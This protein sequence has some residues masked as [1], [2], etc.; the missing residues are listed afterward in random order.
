MTEWVQAFLRHLKVKNFSVHTLQSY[1]E[2]LQQFTDFCATRNFTRVQDFT[3]NTVRLFL[4]S[5][6]AHQYERN[7]TLRKISALRS[8]AGYLVEQGQIQ[9]NPFKLLPAPKRQR[10]LPKFLTLQEVNRL[11]D[12]SAHKGRFA[13]RNQALVELMYSSGLRRSEI[14]GLTIADVDFFNGVVKVLGKGNKERFVPVTQEALQA[15]RQYLATRPAYKPSD[16]L[17]LG[18][19]G[20]P[21]TGDGLAY[22]FKNL[23]IQS[24]I[25]RRMSPHSM[26]H[27]F[28]TH[29]LN[30]GCDL[31]SLQEMLGHSSLQSTQVY[32]HVSLDKLKNVYQHAHPKSKENQL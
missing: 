24:N 11:I 3:L 17:F 2:D 26:R 31:R 13:T 1:S 7:T 10:L 16:A 6:A 8:F 21:L 5:L 25:A 15:L 19:N 9:Q 4:A 22:I 28:A 12:T 14:T 23:T 30:N 32:T 18:K 27:S 20:T 29:L